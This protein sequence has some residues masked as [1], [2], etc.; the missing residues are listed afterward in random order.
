MLLV[1][2]LELCRKFFVFLGYVALI[3][4]ITGI[5]IQPSFGENTMPALNWSQP[6]SPVPLMPQINTRTPFAQ[7]DRCEKSYG[8]NSRVQGSTD[9]TGINGFDCRQQ[10]AYKPKELRLFP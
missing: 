2:L 7:P 9:F 6:L 8:I 3:T 4:L 5:R 10:S 1:S